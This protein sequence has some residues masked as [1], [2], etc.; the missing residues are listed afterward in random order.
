MGDFHI[1]RWNFQ[2]FDVP[3]LSHL[4]SNR[5]SKK[6]GSIEGTFETIEAGRQTRGRDRWGKRDWARDRCGV[7]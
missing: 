4:D 5:N 6:Y 7:S 3:F 2:I 1:V